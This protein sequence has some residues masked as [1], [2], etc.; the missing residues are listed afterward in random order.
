M[1]KTYFGSKD[2]N[3]GPKP[4][5]KPWGA[6][7]WFGRL[8][9][10]L[11]LLFALIFLLNALK[12]CDN[13]KTA[14]KDDRDVPENI[15]NPEGPDPVRV[16]ID[17]DVNFPLDI[18]DPGPNLPQPGD[19]FLPEIND[20]DIITDDETGQQ[21]VGNRL[22]VI[23]D[24]DANDDTFRQWADEFK[25]LYPSDDYKILAYD[26]L[27]KTLQIQVPQTERENI[28]RNL[29]KQITDISFLIFPES[30]MGSFAQKPNDPA[31]Q[32]P[33]YSWY[34]EPIQAYEAWE[35]T[36][37]DSSIVVAV[38]DS[39]FDLQHDELNSRRVV[40]PFSVPRRTGNVAP[41][42]GGCDEVPFRHG[43]LVACTAIGNMNNR[44]GTTGIAPGCKF[45][46]VSTGHQMT[47]MTLLQ[48]LLYSIY[49]GA[50]VVNISAGDA[51]PPGSPIMT[52]SPEEQLQLS[53]QWRKEEEAVW[54][55]ALDLANARNITIVWAAG[56][57]AMFT[58]LDPSKRGDRSIKV[59]AVDTNLRKADFSN[60]GNY[61]NQ[62]VV[63][64]TISAP[65]VN[66]FGACPYNDY[67]PLDWGAGTSFA[68]PI[69]TGAVALMKSIDPTLTTSEIIQILQETGKPVQGA[70]DIGKLIQIK[71]ALMR[72]KG[73]FAD[74]GDIMSDHSKFVGLWMSTT[75]QDITNNG[76][77]TGEKCRNYY[78]V[79]ST[80]GG[81]SIVYAADTKKDYT[82]PFT[83][84]WRQNEIVITEQTP[85]THPTD[86]G[87]S[88]MNGVMTCAPDSANLLK[89]IMRYPGQ[90]YHEE[91]YLRK[92]SQRQEQEQ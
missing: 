58:A 12:K 60:Y 22:N 19:N 80:Q 88:F 65:G 45:M 14:N 49:Q 1:K 48:G 31:F 28:L 2:S 21:I 37:G 61:P 71:D 55:Y 50:D 39:Y 59:S 36:T 8:L 10:F 68:A 34:F 52:L 13:R 29:P 38:V 26:P 33:D 43:S 9:A 54:D 89:A 87:H 74:F 3:G 78:E 90:S 5:W 77:P 18:Q 4:F 16:P 86:Q 25:T 85:L 51:Y 56:N 91:Y 17:D 83:I 82:A 81:R 6:A 79:T 15:I 84:Q 64:S 66:I 72:V 69:V 53:E 11:I 7:G 73:N 70:P 76:V 62:G 35:I 32:Y 44:R 67:V 20:E 27:T 23:L 92:V 41:P 42:S 57:Q 75:L 63:E 47:S 24:S 46:P 30:I 40:K